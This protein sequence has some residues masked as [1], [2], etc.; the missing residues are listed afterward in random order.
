MSTAAILLAGG[1]GARLRHATN[2]VFVEIA[3]EPLM[4]WSIRAFAACA[5]I[6]ELVLVAREGE[7]QRVAE[8]VEARPP[9]IPV[10]LAT[11]GPTRHASELSG[12]DALADDIGSGA[13]DVVLI[14]DAARP[15]VTPHLIARVADAARAVGGAVP[16]LP[17]GDGVYRLTD[18]GGGI[19]HEHGDLH[20]AQTPQGFRAAELLDAYRRSVG[21]DFAGVDTAETVEHYTD[22]RVITVTGETTNIKVTY[23]DDLET[24]ARIAAD[25]V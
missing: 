10:R 6:D 21:D 4:A 8:I 16:T 24:A 25:R 12:L 19:L 2:K 9:G 18:D 3:G 17:L 5:E 11:G 1:S 15:M 7:H 13:V 23:A 20:R 22:L 14:H